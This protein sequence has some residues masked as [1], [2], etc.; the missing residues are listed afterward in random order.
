VATISVFVSIM[1]L[2]LLL[3]SLVDRHEFARPIPVLLLVVL[4]ILTT[5]IVRRQTR[6]VLPLVLVVWALAMLARMP[7]N[8]HIYHYG[9]A[10]AMPATLVALGLLIGWV[11][12]EI[13]QKGGYGGMLQAATM[14]MLLVVFLVHLLVMSTY[15]SNKTVIV[16][17]GGDQFRADPRGLAV[18]EAVQAVLHATPPNESLVVVP[19]GLLVNYLTRRV[20]P[21][22]QLN[23]TPPA[24]IMYGEDEMLKSFR[25]HPPDLLMMISLDTSEYGPRFFGRDYARLLGAWLD[26]NYIVIKVIDDQSF[27][28]AKLKMVLLRRR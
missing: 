3:Y 7:L 1:T 17:S 10:L 19:E 12:R 28:A 14:A 4:C 27:K 18:N 21:T 23:F 8:A 6:D 11:P 16:G 24:L 5:R 26:E 15:W 13:D 9:F 2:G 20:N 25:E 22:G